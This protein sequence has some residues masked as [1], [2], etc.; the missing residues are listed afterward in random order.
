MKAVAA[1][2]SH[3]PPPPTPTWLDGSGPFFLP[4]AEPDF[5]LITSALTQMCLGCM[6]LVMRLQNVSDTLKNSEKLSRNQ[7][8]F[9]RP[10]FTNVWLSHP[11]GTFPQRGLPGNKSPRPLRREGG[12]GRCS[13]QSGMLTDG[14]N[15]TAVREGQTFHC[16]SEQRGQEASVQRD[17]S[18]DI[19]IYYKYTERHN[20]KFLPSHSSMFMA[21][22]K[23]YMYGVCRWR[24]ICCRRLRGKGEGQYKISCSIY[25][26]ISDASI[27]T[28]FFVLNKYL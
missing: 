17:V 4:K 20:S 6:C 21:S 5:V 19:K 18:G 8:T 15:L 23:L 27:K 22:L 24:T 10:L 7:Q 14:S 26:T 16:S 28:Y 1:F 9:H 3:F 25:G 11:A 2:H 13:D 12:R